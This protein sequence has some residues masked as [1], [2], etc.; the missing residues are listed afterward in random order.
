MYP[1]VG[2]QACTLPSRWRFDLDALTRDGVLL[3]LVPACDLL[4]AG[5]L[6][7]WCFTA[8]AASTMASRPWRRA[9]IGGP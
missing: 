2:L 6:G 5:K 8:G 1:A 7:R 3:Y 9:A 4:F